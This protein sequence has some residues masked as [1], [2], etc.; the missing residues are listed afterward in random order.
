M[1]EITVETHAATRNKQSGGNEPCLIVKDE[2]GTAVVSKVFIRG[3]SKIKWFDDWPHMRIVT[4]A[5]FN[6]QTY[7]AASSG[8]LSQPRM[9]HFRKIKVMRGAIDANKKKSFKHSFLPMVL[10]ESKGKN[11]ACHELILE[12]A[13][14]VLQGRDH[15]WKED[16]TVWIET[17]YEVKPIIF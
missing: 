6:T 7:M 14:M 17:D 5:P 2:A 11:Q 15:G 9:K 4:E 13:C 3:K 8:N 16:F 10:I 1:I 12:G